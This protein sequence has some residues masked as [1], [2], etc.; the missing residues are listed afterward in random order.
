MRKFCALGLS[1]FAAAAAA[2][3]QTTT[4][5][6]N[7]TVPTS[8]ADL[9][10]FD[11]GISHFT[12]DLWVDTTSEPVDWIATEM[13]VDVVGTGSIWHASDETNFGPP[14]ENLNVPFLD[15]S[16][17]DTKA[18]DT[19]VTGPGSAFFTQT[20]LAAPGGIVSNG[21]KIRGLSGAGVE[22][23][24][25]WFDTAANSLGDNFIASRMTFEVPESFGPGDLSLDPT[26]RE[27]FATI[28]GRSTTA[29][30]PGGVSFSFTIYQ[31][32]DCNDN[33]IGDAYEIGQGF[34]RDFNN[35]GLP[36]ECDATLSVSCSFRGVV[37]AVLS[38]AEPGTQ[39]TFQLDGGLTQTRTVRNNGTAT[40]RFSGAASGLHHVD[41]VH[42]DGWSKGGDTSCR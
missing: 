3:G 11:R 39:V 41:A 7:A 19:F 27:P 35:N 16:S 32:G 22:I 36:D 8:G 25:A 21:V 31:A 26:G 10:T 20:T 18:F 15:A 23:P 2:L 12:F 17:S 1:L 6:E 42:E 9:A 33:A 14:L 30:N 24:L 29:T 40:A 34:A 28:I 38:G 37:R 4:L 13:S 5:L